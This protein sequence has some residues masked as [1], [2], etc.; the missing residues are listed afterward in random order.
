[1]YS[2]IARS[3]TRSLLG[4]RYQLTAQIYPTPEESRIIDAH[5][6]HHIEIFY[7]PFRDELDAAAVA[8][9][10]HA[11]TRGLFPTKARDAAAICGSELRALIAAA[12]AFRAFNVTVGDLCRGITIT[13]RSLQAIGEIERI[14]TECV[15]AIDR[16]V[17]AA[18]SYADATEDVF[19]P[20]TDDDRTVPPAEWARTWRR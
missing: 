15:D 7:D 18:G 14:L 16:C 13:H 2:H 8:A 3:Q 9:H 11:R 17:R 6:L 19:A 1:M 20:G 10:A 5:R 12:R 4:K